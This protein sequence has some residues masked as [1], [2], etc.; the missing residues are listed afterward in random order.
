MLINHTKSTPNLS[1]PDELI[2]KNRVISSWKNDRDILKVI[3]KLNMTFSWELVVSHTPL[4]I[5]SNFLV[6]ARRF[7]RRTFYIGRLSIKLILTCQKG[8]NMTLALTE[9]KQV[10]LRSNP[11]TTSKLHHYKCKE[12]IDMCANK[13]MKN[14]RLPTN[15]RRK[16]PL[17]ESI[18]R[19]L[20][21]ELEKRLTCPLCLWILINSRSGSMLSGSWNSLEDRCRLR[22]STPL[23]MDDGLVIRGNPALKG[24]KSN[25]KTK[26]SL[27]LQTT[28][29]E[30]ST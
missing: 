30:N 8:A 4:S 11:N 2:N 10:S 21:Q 1:G 5:F 14:Y 18:T 22:N 24:S 15:S 20:C 6:H 23:P 12:T 3:L 9:S 19:I 29:Y 7:E 13:P 25:S 27:Q 16:V 28:K 26:G 17:G